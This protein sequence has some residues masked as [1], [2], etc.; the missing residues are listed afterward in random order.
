VYVTASVGIAFAGPGSDIPERLLRDA[1][2][3]MYQAKLK[4][5]A[6]HQVIDLREQ[7]LEQRRVGLEQELRG[8]SAR[9]ELRTDYQ[10]IVTTSDGRIT[11][12]EALLRW[13]HPTKGLL[14][15]TT[16]VNG[17]VP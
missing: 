1:D 14:M 11:G 6:R 13:D 4:G 3:A 9:G 17:D 5:G 12:V 16:V 15:P 7:R 10:P 8:A 2:V